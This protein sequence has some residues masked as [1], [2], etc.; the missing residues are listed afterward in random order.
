MNKKKKEI[1]YILDKY[2][3]RI[4]KLNK[5]DQRLFLQ[6][7]FDSI[8]KLDT[9]MIA[10]QNVVFTS[11]IILYITIINIFKINILDYIILLPIFILSVLIIN[12]FVALRWVKE[13]KIHKKDMETL[14]KFLEK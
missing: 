4:K 2:S 5:P 6:I 13:S 12:R 3:E 8:K 9:N 7:Y 10:I 14:L 11:M 1:P